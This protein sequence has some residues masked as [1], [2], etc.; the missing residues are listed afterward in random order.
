[1]ASNDELAATYGRASAFMKTLCDKDFWLN[2]QKDQMRQVSDFATK[3]LGDY[4]KMA[5]RIE[6]S[7]LPAEGSPLE[8]RGVEPPTSALRTLRSPN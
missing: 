2:P 8:R 7:T 3:T 4:K 1:M 5:D 6:G